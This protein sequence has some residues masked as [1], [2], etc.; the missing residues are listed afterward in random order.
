MTAHPPE[1]FLADFEAHAIKVGVPLSDAAREIILA[2]ERRAE[3]LNIWLDQKLVLAEFIRAIPA[4]RKVFL[5]HGIDPMRAAQIAEDKAVEDG[6]DTYHDLNDDLYSSDDAF[7]NRSLIGSAAIARARSASKPMISSLDLLSA[8]FD[9]HDSN[10]PVLRNED[11]ADERL[12][13]PFNTLSHL[14]G[15]FHNEFWIP[16]DTVKKELDLLTPEALRREP[17]ESAPAHIRNGLFSFFADH[18]DY[19]KN[20]F[21]VMPFRVSP[22]LE[23]VHT[24]LKT[25]LSDH[26]FKLL[27]A[28]DDVYSENVFSNI[29]VYMHGCR[30]AVSVIE[31]MVSDQHNANVA[32]EIGYMLG[33]KKDVCLLKEKTVPALPSDLQGRFYIEFDAFSIEISVRKSIERWLRDR[34]LV[35]SDRDG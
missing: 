2:I 14:F 1:Y 11:W 6:G 5:R 10:N 18:P 3:T 19:S 4:F 26:G 24:T 23:L 22:Q 33:Q 29:E 25:I 27:R 30:F 12:H 16:I 32:L 21:L 28:D 34:R 35:G 7:G 17:I 15:R 20:C 9:V 13:V 8:L 31:R